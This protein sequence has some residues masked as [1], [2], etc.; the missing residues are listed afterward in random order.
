[1]LAPGTLVNGRYEIEALI[2]QGAAGAVYRA[3]DRG[4]GKPIALK[5]LTAAEWAANFEREARLLAG[6]RHPALPRILDAFAVSRHGSFLA[7]QF[8]PG[9][10][11][12]RVLERGAPPPLADALRWS[13]Q[14][15]EAIGYLHG[16]TPPLIHR[17]IKPGNLKLGPDGQVM[18]LDFG[19]ARDSVSATA[20]LSMIGYTPQYAPLE[21]IQGGATDRRSDYYALGATIYHLLTGQ[22]PADALTRAAA[23][24]RLLP[25]PIA[26]PRSLNRA[27]SPLLDATLCHYLEPNI[28][29]RPTTLLALRDALKLGASGD[30][31]N[32]APPS[33]RSSASSAGM[34]T[35]FAGAPGALQGSSAGMATMLAGA[36]HRRAAPVPIPIIPPSVPAAGYPVGDDPVPDAARLTPV[37]VPAAALARSPRRW[38]PLSRTQSLLLLG[39]ITILLLT[40]LVSTQVRP[41]RPFPPEPGP[42]APSIR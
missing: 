36:Q 22:P 25:D 17:D 9:D 4:L 18:L 21:Q 6:L 11:L 37:R 19:L 35:I 31:P 26:S 24:I 34:A 30:A 8:V 28:D 14:L 41:P 7:M 39:L 23:A 33:R 38:L 2:G 42:S 1:M 20:P 32:A 10:D 13:A 16:R 15:I 5:Q 12:G 40:Y 3:H 29:Q 27:I